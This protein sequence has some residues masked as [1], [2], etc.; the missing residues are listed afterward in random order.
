MAVVNIFF[1]IIRRSICSFLV[2]LPT[3]KRT[4]REENPTVRL[5]FV[6]RRFIGLMGILLRGVG[7]PT[8][9]EYDFVFPLRQF[10][11]L[12]GI[13]LRGARDRPAREKYPTVRLV[14]VLGRFT[15]V[16][17]ILL[18]GVRDPT[19]FKYHFGSVLR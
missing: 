13:L 4:P 17:R 14:F 16:M 2:D 15:G 12:K 9:F 5:V 6:L 19:A 3:M 11:G 1:R 7:D 8:A 18:R 10:T